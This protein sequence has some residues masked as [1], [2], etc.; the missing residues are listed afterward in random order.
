MKHLNL[1]LLSTMSLTT[2]SSSA[3]DFTVLTTP[4]DVYSHSIEAVAGARNTFKA[5]LDDAESTDADKAA[6]MQTYQQNATPV[7]G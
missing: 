2:W 6:A 3:H 1:I 5:V 4:D 7:P